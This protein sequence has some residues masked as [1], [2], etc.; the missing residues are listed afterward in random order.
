MTSYSQKSPHLFPCSLVL[1]LFHPCSEMTFIT[2]DLR[3]SQP[4]AQSTVSYEIKTGCSGLHPVQSEKPSRTD[5]TASLGNGFVPG[6]NCPHSEKVLLLYPVIV[7]PFNLC[8]S[9]H[10]DEPGSSLLITFSQVVE[11]CYFVPY[12]LS[13]SAYISPAKILSAGFS[14]SKCSSNCRPPRKQK[15]SKLT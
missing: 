12:K 6:H 3:R 1:I 4:P 14:S 2:G 8:L 10:V 7:S 9:H 5:G 11:S 13:S 15:P